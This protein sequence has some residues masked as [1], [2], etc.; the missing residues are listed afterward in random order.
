MAVS[1]Y[2]R[3]EHTSLETG[4]RAKLKV[5]ECVDCGVEI[6]TA[7]GKKRC[8]ICSDRKHEERRYA[9]DERDRKAKLAEQRPER[10]SWGLPTRFAQK[11][12]RCCLKCP[13]VKVTFHQVDE[14]GRDYC[15]TEWYRGL[16]KIE[17]KNTPACEVVA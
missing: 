8:S 17:S 3:N 7:G 13:L 14:H 11:T 10:H 5:R 4:S 12:E 1:Q 9:R 15:W 6:P 16:D 2:Y